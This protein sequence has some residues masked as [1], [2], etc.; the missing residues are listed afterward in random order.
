MNF[1]FTKLMSQARDMQENMKKVQEHVRSQTIHAESGAG[2]V[3]VEMSGDMQVRSLH[4]D[5]SLLTS[6]KAQIVQDLVVAAMN[7]AIVEA[8]EL[9]KSEM[10]KVTP[11]IPGMNLPFG[12]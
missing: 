12:S 9:M 10:Q 5:S 11:A 3:K 2:L 6:D 4:I 7:T 8:Q 1:D